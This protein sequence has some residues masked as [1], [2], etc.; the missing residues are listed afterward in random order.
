MPMPRLLNSTSLNAVVPI[1][2]HEALREIAKEQDRTMS[3]LVR[4]ILGAHVAKHRRRAA[5]KAG[6]PKQVVLAA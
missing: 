4:G 3:N 5:A 6:E 2:L 1:P